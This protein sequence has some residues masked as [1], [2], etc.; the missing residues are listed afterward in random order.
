MNKIDSV[1]ILDKKWCIKNLNSDM[2]RPSLFKNF[3]RFDNLNTTV[4]K[5]VWD[6][7]T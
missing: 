6:L 1:I 3:N 5:K 7:L 2:N 4:F